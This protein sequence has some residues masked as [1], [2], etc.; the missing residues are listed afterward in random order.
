MN[1]SHILAGVTAATLCAIGGGL[2]A[3]QAGTIHNGWNYGVDSFKDGVSGSLGGMFEMYGLGVK[4][5]GETIYVGIDARLPI[6]GEAHSGVLGGSITWGD[7]FF[8][9]GGNALAG[10]QGNLFAVRFAANNDSGVSSLGLY[11]KASG[12]N[13][14]AQNSGFASVAAQADYVKKSGGLPSVGDLS[15]P[16][17]RVYFKDASLGVIS[18]AQKVTDSVYQALDSTALSALGFNLNAALNGATP[19]ESNARGATRQTFGFK[20]T[21]TE[22]MIGDF[23]AHVFAECLND[24][25]AVKGS[26]EAPKQESTPEPIS[27]LGLA[28]VGALAIATRQSRKL[29]ASDR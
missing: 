18:Q 27:L 16:E 24:G 13:V 5:E 8:N 6:T 26:L 11:Q 3:A 15:E 28:A 22:G 17:A 25:V 12:K 19:A 1:I 20:F 7:L 10:Q 2:P 23:V 21:R 4:Q 29:A 9:F 14:A